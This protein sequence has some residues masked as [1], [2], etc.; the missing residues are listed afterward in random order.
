MFEC[1]I[2]SPDLLLISILFWV[3]S[4]YPAVGESGFTEI[5]GEEQI[6]MNPPAYPYRGAECYSHPF[7]QRIRLL[8]QQSPPMPVESIQRKQKSRFPMR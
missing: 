2:I 8:F 5:L 4:G 1:K 3:L 6:A 7:L